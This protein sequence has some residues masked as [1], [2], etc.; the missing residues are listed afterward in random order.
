VFDRNVNK[1]L[2]NPSNIEISELIESDIESEF[3]S[4]LGYGTSLMRQK[5]IKSVLTIKP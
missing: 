1:V 2:S 4:D 3:S 5:T